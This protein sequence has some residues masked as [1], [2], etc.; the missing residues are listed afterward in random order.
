MLPM[1][2]WKWISGVV[3]PA[4]SFF[5]FHILVEKLR[6]SQVFEGRGPNPR[7]SKSQHSQAAEVGCAVNDWQ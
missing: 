6:S 3:C 2:E 1:P 5:Q 4:T 7:H